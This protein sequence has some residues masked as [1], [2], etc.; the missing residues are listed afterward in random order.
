VRKF[1]LFGFIA[2]LLYQLIGFFT[3]IEVEHYLIRK[4][5]KTAIKESVPENQLISFHFTNKESKK[6]RWIKPNE[7]QLLGRFYDVIKKKKRNGVW[8]FQC[9]DDRQETALFK[10]L[11]FATASNLVNSPYQNPVHGWLK[12]MNEPM[13][14]ISSL[15]VKLLNFAI[16]DP[17]SIGSALNHYLSRFLPIIVPPPEV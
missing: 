11:D 2:L 17:Q 14:P 4:D 10:K 5:I 9:I 15:E 12:L 8:Y 1:I 6:L 7:F 13:E 16:K 3:F